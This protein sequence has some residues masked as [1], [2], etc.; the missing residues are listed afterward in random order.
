MPVP[1]N[2]LMLDAATVLQPGFE[3]LKAPDW[4]RRRVTEGLGGVALFGRNIES[5]AQVTELCASLHAENPALLIAIDEEGGDV[6]RLETATGSSYPGNHALGAVAA[7]DLDAG[8][9]LTEKVAAA[10]GADLA[11]LGIDLD[12]APDADVNSNPDNP[13]IGVRSFGDE[14]DLVARLTAGY[15]RGL[16]SRGVAA[17]AKHFP[18]HGDTAVDSH[19]GLPTVD[20]DLDALRAGPLLPFVAAIEAG[21]RTVMSAHI[22]LPRLDDVPATMSRRAL[23]TLLRTELGFQGVIITDGIE[24]DAISRGYGIVE[25]TVRAL[26]AGADAVCVGGGLV[27]EDTVLLLQFAL[28]QAVREGRLSEERLHDAAERVRALSR[29]RLDHITEIDE[30]PDRAD[31]R[32]G[33]TVAR[34][35]LSVIP[36]A[37]GLPPF[38][39]QDGPA[40]VVE[41]QTGANI[42]VGKQT[43]WGLIAALATALP[44]TTG[45]RVIVDGHTGATQSQ[46]GDGSAIGPAEAHAAEA[47]NVLAAAGERPIVLVARNLHRHAEAARAVDRLVRAIVEHGRDVAIV[48]LGL[49][50]RVATDLAKLGATVV[51]THGAARVCAQAAAEALTGLTI[52]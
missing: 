17:C 25:G 19:H 9:Q 27:G 44:G 13:V 8:V 5:T 16:Q 29:W 15:V 24:M 7:R 36:P 11:T 42:A 37:G 52:A 45:I 50:N 20:D 1:T 28:V 14:P 32:V 10:I 2:A 35:A 12:Y 26:A 4:L 43:S 34:E 40:Y 18:G 21:V 6:T 47:A 38:R 46:N 51:L 41:F 30:A 22:L 48:E 23:H 49:P 39:R 31:R 33:M 3:G